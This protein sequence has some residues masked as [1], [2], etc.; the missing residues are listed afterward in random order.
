MSPFSHSFHLITHAYAFVNSEK[1]VVFGFSETLNHFV[2]PPAVCC[3][4]AVGV[5]WLQLL[6]LQVSGNIL[7]LIKSDAKICVLKKTKHFHPANWTLDL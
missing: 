2:T 4:S 5:I 7:K 3:V 6:S 1:L